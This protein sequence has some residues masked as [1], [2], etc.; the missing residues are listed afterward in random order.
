LTKKK[1]KFNTRV[2]HE[3]QTPEE[4]FGAVS[5]PIYQTST[6]KQNEF[7]E[8]IFDYSRADNPTRKNLEK[9]IASLEGGIGSIAF[10][11]GMAAISSICQLFK[12]GDEF[13][14]TNNVY[15]G[16]Y[17]LMENIMNKFSLKANWVD[18]S[19]IDNIKNSISENTKM[20][21]I[22][23]P[24]NPM[25]TISDI[26]QISLLCSEKNIL[27]VV[28]NTFMS[29]YFQ[30]PIQLGA[31]IVIHS[32]TKYIGGHSD[33]IGGAVIVKD[34]QKIL[35]DLKFIQMSV[36]A[37]PGP[38][39]CW[40]TQR[41]IK[42][43]SV[44]MEKHNKNASVLAKILNDSNKVEKVFYPGLDT[45]PQH[46]LAKK[47]HSIQN[48]EHGYGGMISIELGSL[49]KAKRFVK[50]LNIFTLAESLGGVESLVC[51]PATM[52]H[53]SMPEELRA[54]VGITDG[55]IRLSVGIEDIDDLK[56]DI[57]KAL[58]AL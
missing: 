5:L 11:S 48:G 51:H 38:F 3:G 36:G 56:D 42:T 53:A 16:T 55:L 46:D 15:G 22:E 21:F 47:Q 54:Q 2:I 58:K 6:F 39:D 33:I 24:T 20:I 32:T 26:K 12:A 44:R 30:R 45:H 7:G 34:D 18:T 27:L 35:D 43:L 23:T 40:L 4:P 31:D 25:M 17:R 8:Y 29:P 14:F 28:D 41:S 9:N 13:I 57:S 19:C 1:L 52:T 10:S 49:D 37:I 50:G